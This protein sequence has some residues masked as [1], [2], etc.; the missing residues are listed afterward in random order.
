MTSLEVTTGDRPEF[1]VI[2][3]HGLGADGHDFEP[4]VPELRLPDTLPTRFIFPNA[5]MAPVT[6]NGGYVMPA[7]YD[8]ISQNLGEMED[9]KGIRASRHALEALIQKE[10]ARGIPS[11]RVILAGFSQGGAIALFT[12]LRFPRPLGG[13]L[14]LSTYLPL[15]EKLD[16]EAHASNATLPIFM[17]HG[18]MDGV[19]TLAQG[20][21]ARDLLMRKGNRVVWREYAMA[22][23]VCPE[24]IADI[25]A[26]LGETLANC[27][28]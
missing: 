15:P 5:P 10:E 21:A 20:A 24:E 11:R 19:I 6:I 16:M 12:A 26:W 25:G 14:A 8:V 28:G 3:L 23:S 17:G 4:I 9:E 18:R 1:S 22:H 27:K 7:W 13:V 2:W